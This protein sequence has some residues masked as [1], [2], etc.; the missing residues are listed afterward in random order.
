MIVA[1][2]AGPELC[3]KVYEGLMNIAF[4]KQRRIGVLPKQVPLNICNN[5][6][7]D[8]PRNNLLRVQFSGGRLFW[9]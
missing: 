3:L 6:I 2:R 4:N 5:V 7:R 8:R 1:L 9:I